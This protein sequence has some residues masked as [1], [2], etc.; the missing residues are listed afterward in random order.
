MLREMATGDPVAFQQFVTTALPSITRILRGFF[1]RYNIS[2][3][4]ID[5]CVQDTLLK[6]IKTLRKHDEKEVN[7]TWLMKVVRSVLLDRFRK[8][9]KAD[10][11]SEHLLVANQNNPSTPNTD[12]RRENADYIFHLLDKVS[13]DDRK[14]ICMIYLDDLS[15]DEAAT[16]LGIGLQAAYKRHACAIERLRSLANAD[17][18]T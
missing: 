12:H 1:K 11:V 9:G 14:I 5:D 4:Q 3:D 16:T 18:A 13:D 10:S 6:I 15:I 17:S 7:A 8:I 2:S